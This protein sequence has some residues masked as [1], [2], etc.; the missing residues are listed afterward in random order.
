MFWLLFKKLGDFFKSSGH[1]GGIALYGQTLGSLFRTPGPGKL[2]GKMDS[3]S[4]Q[5][6]KVGYHQKFKVYS[7]ACSIKLF[8]AIIYGFL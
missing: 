1:P 8:T 4:S 3:M 5:F 2:A 7:R 6:E